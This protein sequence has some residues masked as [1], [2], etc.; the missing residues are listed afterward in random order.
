MHGRV[1][2]RHRWCPVDGNGR[3]VGWLAAELYTADDSGRTYKCRTLHRVSAL[4][5][6][7]PLFIVF[8][9]RIMLENSCRGTIRARREPSFQSWR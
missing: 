1:R 7:V 8:P 4:V 5:G 9:L 2:A 3:G 6:T